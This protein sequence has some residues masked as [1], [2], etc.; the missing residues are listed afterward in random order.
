VGVGVG[1]ARR[2]ALWARRMRAG[3]ERRA[4]IVLD[5]WWPMRGFGRSIGLVLFTGGVPERHQPQLFTLDIVWRKLSRLGFVTF[6]SGSRQGGE[7]GSVGALAL[8]VR[9]MPAGWVN[10]GPQLLLG[11]SNDGVTYSKH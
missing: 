2:H 4:G 10:R 7:R 8:P 11:E 5:S 6:G 9:P 3:V 1:V